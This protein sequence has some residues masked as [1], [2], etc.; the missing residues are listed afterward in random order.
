[1]GVR[2]FLKLFV[3]KVKIMINHIINLINCFI[4]HGLKLA[5]C[6]MRL[7]KVPF[8]RMN[9]YRVQLFGAS[10]YFGGFVYSVKH[11]Y[12]NQDSHSFFSIIRVFGQLTR[13]ST[14]PGYQGSHFKPN[15]MAQY[16]YKN[17]RELTKMMIVILIMMMK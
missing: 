3:K 16:H 10:P 12:L 1:M 11:N 13:T 4:H 14:N 8:P 6:I 2:F 5:T 9:N 7:T 15:M 17:N